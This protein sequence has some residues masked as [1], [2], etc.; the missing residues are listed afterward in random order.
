MHFYILFLYISVNYH[1]IGG[2]SILT[3]NSDLTKVI[4]QE[5]KDFTRK[6]LGVR[7]P[8]VYDNADSLIPRDASNDM[9]GFISASWQSKCDTTTKAGATQWFLDQGFTLDQIKYDEND[10]L[11]VANILPGFIKDH[12]TGEEI[13][14][15]IID[16]GFWK[17]GDKTPFPPEMIAQAQLDRWKVRY[18]LSTV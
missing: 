14:W 12:V 3:R 8:R 1:H 9:K 17:T 18:C 11:S 16:T 7:Y 2:V 15:N 5:T 10:H 6:H 4:S 13:W